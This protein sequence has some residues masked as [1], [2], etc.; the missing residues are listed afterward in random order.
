VGK[1]ADPDSLANPEVLAYYAPGTA[2]TSGTA[3]G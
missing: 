3:G 1:A 2:G